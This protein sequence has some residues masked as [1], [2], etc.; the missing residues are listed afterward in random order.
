MH[1]LIDESTFDR[2]VH[3]GRVAFINGIIVGCE[4]CKDREDQISKRDQAEADQDSSYRE[5]SQHSG[6]PSSPLTGDD[7]TA[8]AE[9]LMVPDDASRPCIHGYNP[10]SCED[11]GDKSY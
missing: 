2:C 11:C 4:D 7:D 8:T 5:I 1:A 10:G 3:G 9:T 6:L